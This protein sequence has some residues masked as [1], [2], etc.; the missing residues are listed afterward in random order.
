MIFRLTTTPFQALL[1][2][3]KTWK[4]IDDFGVNFDDTRDSERIRTST[5]LKGI[6]EIND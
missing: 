1:R 6:R 3:K 5:I 2:K 4:V